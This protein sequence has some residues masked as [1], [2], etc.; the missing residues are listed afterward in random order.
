MPAL[1]LDEV[2]FRH[3]EK[4]FFRRDVVDAK[5]A[6]LAI[7]ALTPKAEKAIP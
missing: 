5:N 4:L 1:V 2:Q 7:D 3:L 6:L